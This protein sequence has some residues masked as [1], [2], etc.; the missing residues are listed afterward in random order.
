M[1]C[2]SAEERL[3][4]AFL[5]AVTHHLLLAPPP[6]FLGTWLGP[7]GLAPSYPSCPFL[8]QC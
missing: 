1:S 3:T 6:G 2:P 7:E 5:F 4:L 8:G